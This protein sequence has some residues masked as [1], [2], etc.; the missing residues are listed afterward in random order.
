MNLLHR[1]GHPRLDVPIAILS[2]N[3][4]HYLRETLHSLRAQ[5]SEGD[6]IVLFQDGAVNPFSGRRKAEDEDIR[7]CVALFRQL[8]PWGEV[9]EAGHNL[10]IALN[11]ERAEQSMFVERGRPRAL[12]LEDDLVLSPQYLP[13]IRRLL[14]LAEADPRIAYVSAYGNLWAPLAEQRA[15]RGE[16]QHM[17]ENWGF[18]LTRETWRA[19]RPFRERYLSFV[20][21][22]DYAERD[23]A[24]IFAFYAEG[25]WTV[26]VSSQDAARWVACVELGK[27]RL[28]TFACHARYIGEHGEHFRPERYY[29][30]GF[31]RT[32]TFTGRP[33]RLAHPSDGQ[34]AGW[35]E[36]ERRRFRGEIGPFYAAH[37]EPAERTE[38]HGCVAPC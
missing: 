2:F 29:R 12:F 3:R 20:R 27:V 23:N 35:L 1:L 28:T 37:A 24:P 16:L 22:I 25:G 18:A 10:G 17:H 31:D 6:E 14:R 21:N 5:V 11:Y 9:C 32:V 13:T 4:P 33:G 38:V 15:R 7:R 8:I 34:I 26:R 36:T 30:A 19:E